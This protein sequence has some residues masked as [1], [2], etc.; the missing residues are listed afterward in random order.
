MVE[1]AGE[2]GGGTGDAVVFDQNEKAAAV[3]LDVLHQMTEGVTTPR[4][5]TTVCRVISS[6]RVLCHLEQWLVIMWF[7]AVRVMWS[8]NAAQLSELILQQQ[9]FLDIPIP[10]L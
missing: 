5:W 8:K 9:L 6:F 7:T 2:A 1:E 4:C 3:D 10:G